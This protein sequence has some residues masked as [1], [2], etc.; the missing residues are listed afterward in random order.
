MGSE[1]LRNM[2]L[3]NFNCISDQV[4]QIIKNVCKELD[5]FSSS[6]EVNGVE[7]KILS[8]HGYA[9]VFKTCVG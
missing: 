4:V 1:E 3:V 6:V 5:F 8:E 9:F 2:I 7:L